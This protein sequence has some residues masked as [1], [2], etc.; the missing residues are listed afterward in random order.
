MQE[1]AE[2]RRQ[3]VGRRFDHGGWKKSVS[4]LSPLLI[5]GSGIPN[6]ATD[7]FFL[8][9]GHG[10]SLQFLCQQMKFAPDGELGSIHGRIRRHLSQ[11]SASNGDA[12]S[13]N[14]TDAPANCGFGRW[15]GVV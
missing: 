14:E 9:A 5:G 4:W 13:A 8:G 12:C 11:F 7:A 6:E 3:Q 10:D 2:R 1:R 15:I